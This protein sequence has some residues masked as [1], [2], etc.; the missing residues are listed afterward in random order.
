MVLAIF[1]S[2]V[3]FNG[4]IESG[5][6]RIRDVPTVQQLVIPTDASKILPGY[7]LFIGFCLS[8]IVLSKKLE[9]GIASMSQAR[10]VSRQAAEKSCM[11]ER[12][13][14]RAKAL[15]H[16]SGFTAR[17]KSCPFKTA[18][19]SAP[20]QVF[21]RPRSPEHNLHRCVSYAL[22]PSITPS[23]ALSKRRVFPRPAKYS[24]TALHRA[25]PSPSSAAARASR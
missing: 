19:I 20:C 25:P 9:R 8:S 11:L 16:F 17:L 2:F 7:Y 15:S 21:H 24:P 12:H 10:R 14:S 23:R 3:A 22:D 5:V 13:P 18:S 4:V 1:M 6:G